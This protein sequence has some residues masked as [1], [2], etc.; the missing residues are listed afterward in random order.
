VLPVTREALLQSVAAQLAGAGAAPPT[1]TDLRGLRHSL[2]ANGLSGA[3]KSRPDADTVEGDTLPPFDPVTTT[4]SARDGHSHS[5]LAS[6]EARAGTVLFADIRNFSALA[7]TLTTLELADLLNS[8]FVRACEPI[9]QQGGWIVKL[10]GDGIL[11]MFEPRA[12]APN[13]AERGLKAGLF[14]CIVAQRFDQWLERRFPD[15]ALPDFAVG[16][17]V[18]TGDVMVCRINTGEGR[19]HHHH[20]RHRQRCL[21]PGGADQETRRQPGH[22]ARHAGAGRHAFRSRQARLAAGART[23][24]AGGDHRDHRPAAAAQRGRPRPADTATSS[25]TTSC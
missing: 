9:L 10:L 21:A 16:I 17:G 15:K 25:R 4:V 8:Y 24:L 7:E 2:T 11:A 5:S 6:Q 23:R 3:A 19:G 18:H 13:H 14:L 22:L 12:S 1:T 20:R